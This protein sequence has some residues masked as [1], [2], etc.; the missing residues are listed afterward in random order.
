VNTSV[1]T[2]QADGLATRMAKHFGH[3]VPVT[4]EAGVTRVETR[5][6]RFEL[7]PNGGVLEVRLE[8]VDRE[9]LPRLRE[10]VE[11]HLQRFARGE[12]LLFEW[13]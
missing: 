10:V 9:G 3:K 8:P 12:E 11:S 2:S 7:E 1:R 5:F 6:G 13:R 4:T